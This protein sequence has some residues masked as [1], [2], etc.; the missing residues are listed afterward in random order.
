MN[1]DEE[2]KE[3]IKQYFIDIIPIIHEKCY[4]YV[5]DLAKEMAYKAEKLDILHIPAIKFGIYHIIATH[6]L[7]NCCIQQKLVLSSQEGDFWELIERNLT[8]AVSHAVKFAKHL[9]D[10]EEGED[11]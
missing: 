11:E 6:V 10:K 1:E 2:I 9:I 8:D 3:K 5:R 7:V 4:E